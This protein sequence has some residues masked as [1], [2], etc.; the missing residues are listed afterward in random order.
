MLLCCFQF[1]SKPPSYSFPCDVYFYSCPGSIQF[2]FC[3]QPPPLSFMKGLKFTVTKKNDTLC[4]N[5][6]VT[7][8]IPEVRLLL[9]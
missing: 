5:M 3:I 2:Q 9:K 4:I 8:T 7:L 1:I 6:D